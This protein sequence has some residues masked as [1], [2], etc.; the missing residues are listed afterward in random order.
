VDPRPRRTFSYKE[1]K[2]QAALTRRMD[3]GQARG[4]DSFDKLFREVCRLL[5][6]EAPPKEGGE[7]TGG[8]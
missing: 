2:H 3:L 4:S 5:G 6:R 1:T 7:G 8:E